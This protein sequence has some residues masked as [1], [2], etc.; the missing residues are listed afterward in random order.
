MK[1]LINRLRILDQRFKFLLIILNKLLKNVAS[2]IFK[3]KKIIKFRKLVI[4]KENM[5]KIK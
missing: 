3:K 4:V 5:E 2:I 1:C